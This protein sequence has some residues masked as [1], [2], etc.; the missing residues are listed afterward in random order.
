M[1]CLHMVSY[2]NKNGNYRRLF[3]ICQEKKNEIQT[4]KEKQEALRILYDNRGVIFVLPIWYGRSIIFQMLPFMMQKKNSN[5][6][7]P[8][9][10]VVMPFNAIMQDQVMDLIK[11]YITACFCRRQRI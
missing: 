6:D 7:L 5:C 9:V 2:V 1:K 10:I 11:K 8:I 4:L 3:G